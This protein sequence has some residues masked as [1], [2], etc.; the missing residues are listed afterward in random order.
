MEWIR[1]YFPKDEAEAK[2]RAHL[3]RLNSELIGK[4]REDLHHF[5]TSSI[6]LNESLD[7]VLFIYHRVYHSWGWPG[8]HV[9]DGE[10]LFASCLREIHEETGLRYIKPITR[11]PMGMELQT[12]EAHVKEHER[13][14]AHFHINFTFGF[15]AREGDELIANFSETQGVKWIPIEDLE[16]YVNEEHMLPIYRKYIHRLKR[17]V[18]SLDITKS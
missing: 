2:D 4:S 15:T 11:K 1:D 18:T 10:E 14:M 8:G 9:E 5:T 16:K 3:L 17:M 6:I 7:K 13:I 12:V